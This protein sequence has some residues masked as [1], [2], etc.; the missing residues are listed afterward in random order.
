MVFLIKFSPGS[1]MLG[2]FVRA[3]RQRAGMSIAELAEKTTYS[4]TYLYGIEQGRKIPTVKVLTVL[5]HAFSLTA[6]EERYL[7]ALCGRITPPGD[8]NSKDIQGYLDALSP[9]PAAVIDTEWTV[10]AWNSSFEQVFRGIHIMPNLLHWHYSSA[11]SRITLLNWQETSDWCIGHFRM[12]LAIGR[13][14]L[15]PMI[16]ALRMMPGFRAQWDAQVIPINPSTRWWTIR[17]REDGH[18]RT[19]DMQVWRGAEGALLLGVDQT[20]SAKTH[21]LTC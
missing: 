12:E 16:E 2:E 20:K 10:Q 8:V 17:D 19:F 5:A 21:L 11:A 18:E 4:V 9:H 13:A 6:W 3:A 1:M 15:A 7:L 14:R